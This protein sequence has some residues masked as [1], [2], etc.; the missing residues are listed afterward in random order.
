MEFLKF[1]Y[2]LNRLCPIFLFLKMVLV[3]RHCIKTPKLVFLS[4]VMWQY[5]ISSKFWYFECFL[6]RLH[7]IF[8]FFKMI[9]VLTLYINIQIRFPEPGYATVKYFMEILKFWNFEWFLNRLCP[10]YL[11]LKVVLINKYDQKN[12]ISCSW[13]WS[14]NSEI[15]Q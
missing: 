13:A 4:L 8:L 1:S 6:N 7:P 14:C 12:L 11:F 3:Y 9:L 2:F 15:F 10:I 5:N